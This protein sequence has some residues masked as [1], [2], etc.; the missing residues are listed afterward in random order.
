MIAATVL[1]DGPVSVL[2]YRCC[3]SPSDASYVEC[4]TTHSLSYVSAGSFGYS[5]RGAHYDMVPGSLLSGSANDEFVCTHEHHLG[6]DRCLS[7]QFSPEWMQTNAASSKRWTSLALPPIPELVVLGELTRASAEGDND[8]AL[9][10]AA[11]FLTARFLDLQSP[12]PQQQARPSASAR[13]LV[14]ETALWLDEN[15]SSHIDLARTA[16]VAN[17]SPFHFLRLF[18]RVLGVT[19]HQY[20]LRSRLRHAARLLVERDRAITDIA[21]Q[22]GFADLS[23]FTRTFRRVAGVSPR[24]F[25][26]AAAGDRKNFQ[27]L[28]RV[29]LAK[30]P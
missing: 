28:L 7:V 6:G 11:L 24:E 29:P 27:A 26:N 21:Y 18:T 15:A 5:T 25:R 13:K 8:I 2:D 17:L 12:S 4:H 22:V 14:V 23:N 3:A 20:L 16:R 1:I 30:S 19:P 9:D 10:E